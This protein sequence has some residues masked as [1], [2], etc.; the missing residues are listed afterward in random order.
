MSRKVRGT[1]TRADN[2]ALARGRRAWAQLDNSESWEG[3]FHGGGL[4]HLEGCGVE[5]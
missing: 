5:G 4:N 3:L 1:G 2:R